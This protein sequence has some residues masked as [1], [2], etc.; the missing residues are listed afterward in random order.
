MFR[1]SGEQMELRHG[2]ARATVVEVGGGLRCYD[3]G[4]VPVID[5]YAEDEM[6]SAGR[7][8]VLLPWPNR[9]E[10]G[11]W[12]WD[13]K[14]Q[15]LAIT[16]VGKS[17]AN[18]GL[19]R[20][21]GWRLERT[22]EGSAIARH[23]LHPQTG[24]PFRLAAELHY[25]LGDEGLTVRVRVE[26]RTDAAAP[27]GLGFHPY[28]TA[29]DGPVDECTLTVPAAT[30][31]EVNDRGLPVGR[32]PVEGTEYDF[33]SGRLIGDQVLDTPMTDLD[34]V[35][36]RTSVVLAGPDRQVTV[37]M[38]ETFGYAQVFTGDTVPQPERRRHGLAVEPM[39][40][41]ANALVT[42]EGLRTLGPGEAL[43]GSWGITPG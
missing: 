3:V 23:E 33:R 13:G 14:D 8:Q 21:A 18:H 30:R 15:Q 26:N 34:R 40:C 2:S 37:W 32:R 24:Y 6:A 12:R 22:G 25:S 27:V 4:G 28:V 9:V 17:N 1:P 16:E 43:E 41:P 29:S 20:W 7:G 35:A 10:D 5:G 39:T 36:G 11:K 31:I 42:G 38:D 19:V